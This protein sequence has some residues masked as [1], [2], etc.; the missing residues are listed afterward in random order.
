MNPISAA[1][2]RACERSAPSVPYCVRC[3]SS[4]MT[5]TS[6][7]ASSTA[8]ARSP[9]GSASSNF[10]IVVI[11]VRPRPPVSNSARCFPLF[12]VFGAGKPQRSKVS[13]IC[14]SSCRRSVT[15]RIVA[16]PSAGSRRSFVA[17]QNAVSDFPDPWVCQITPP[18]S[19]GRPPVR[20]RSSAFPTARY[21]W[22]RG[23]FL[24]RRPRSGSK[25]T[26][27]RSTSSTA[28]G[29]NSPTMS[30]AC[31][32]GSTPNRSRTSSSVNGATDFHSA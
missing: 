12:A 32:A 29:D 20:I 14:R 22:Y 21:C 25:S 10:W 17:N 1:R 28:A 3:A 23:S 16:F 18:R 30:R 8:V 13:A 6:S 4:T 27:S 31:P 9:A 24:T 2:G 7:E 11:T 26:K 5:T 15:T 19:S